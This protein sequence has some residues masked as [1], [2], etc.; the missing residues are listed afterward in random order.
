MTTEPLTLT[1]DEFD[2][3]LMAL[4]ASSVEWMTKAAA[5]KERDDSVHERLYREI[6][7]KFSVLWAKFYRLREGHKNS[8]PDLTTETPDTI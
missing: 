2:N 4:N 3:I 1:E 8:Q 7:W 5:A 6:S